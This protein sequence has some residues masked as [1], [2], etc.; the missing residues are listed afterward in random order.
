MGVHY[1]L[2]EMFSLFG[3][4]TEEGRECAEAEMQSEHNC[5]KY[6]KMHFTKAEGHSEVSEV[7]LT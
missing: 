3:L 4:T 2:Y 6:F 1:V 5:C 7:K